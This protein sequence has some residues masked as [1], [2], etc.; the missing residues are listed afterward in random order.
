VKERGIVKTLI[1][2]MG[3]KGEAAFKGPVRSVDEKE[4]WPDCTAVDVEGRNVAFEV[5]ELVSQTAIEINQTG[6]AKWDLWPGDSAV[7]RLEEILRKK[8]QS[9]FHGK[10]F[11]K[12]VLV[13]HIDEPAL[14]RDR[15]QSLLEGHVFP[16]L[17]NIDEVYLLMSFSP[18]LGGGEYPCFKLA[19]SV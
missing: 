11:A 4:Q 7:K 18:K 9:S 5:T 10:E 8:D 12:V 16:H 6:D 3:R 13:I 17:R 19:F 14:D 2:S 1:E 15:I